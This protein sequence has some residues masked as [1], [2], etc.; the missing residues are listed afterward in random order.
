[1]KGEVMKKKI[2]IMLAGL[3]LAAALTGCSGSAPAPSEPEKKAETEKA[4]ETAEE[5]PEEA[6]EEK[7]A[8]AVEEAGEWKPEKE[9]TFV[10]GFD[11]GGAADIPARVMAKYMSKYAGVDVV[12]TNITGSGGQIAAKQVMEM[13]PDGYTLL[14]VPV[15]YYLQAALGNADF[16]YEDFTPVTMWC[17]SWVGI[18]VKA[19]SP[20][21]TYADFIAAA[22][23]PE[24][25]KMGTVSGT[26]PQLAAL[27]IQDK[28]GIQFKAVDIAVDNK[29]TELLSG[30]IDAYIDSVGSLK[31][32][33]E[34]GDFRVLMAF[35]YEDTTIPGYDGIEKAEGL[36]YSNFDYLLQ[37]FGMWMPKGTDSAIAAYY[38]D[39][40][41]KCAEDPDCIAE[42]NSL[43]YGARSETPEDY[44]KICENTLSQTKEAVSA[45]LGN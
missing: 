35:A 43:G 7:E 25:V 29:A 2:S 5:K 20:Y 44:A 19:D 28:E 15:G 6:V 3:M 31:Q 11:A 40:V 4:T 27:A 41:K 9:V 34:S 26:L 45:I 37:S 18:A 30:R 38:A 8:E 12:V 10:V 22:A 23:E 32:Y 17:D 16:T 39:I 33:V 13:E 36:G 21:E 24:A 14:H 42:L 1:M